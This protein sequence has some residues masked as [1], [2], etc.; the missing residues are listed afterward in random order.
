VQNE[1]VSKFLARPKKVESQKL[2][3]PQM[4]TG[5]LV[6]HIV[7]AMRFIQDS[8]TFCCRT[9]A[10]VCKTSSKLLS[11]TS[12]SKPGT[13]KFHLTST[14]Y[15]TNLPLASRKTAITIKSHDTLRFV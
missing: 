7:G 14:I 10:N 8:R 9:G 4:S 3:A 12:S 6:S 11:L 5:L 15:F 13:V 2:T 1:D